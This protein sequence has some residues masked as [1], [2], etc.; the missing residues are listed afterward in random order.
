MGYTFVIIEDN[1]AYHFHS[2]DLPTFLKSL[3]E[4]IKEKQTFNNNKLIIHKPA[5]SI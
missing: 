3:Q 1:K 5:L 2:N 4:Y